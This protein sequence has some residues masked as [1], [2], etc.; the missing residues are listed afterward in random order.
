MN[1]PAVDTPATEEARPVETWL[2]AQVELHRCG[3]SCGAIDGVCGAQTVGALRAFQR[4]HGI[5]ANGDL[6]QPTRDCLRLTAP[7]FTTHTFTD[8]ELAQLHPVPETWLGKSTAPAL[9]YATALEMVAEHYRASQNFVRQH[10]PEVDWADVQ[11]G[12][13]VKV[14][15]VERATIKGRV[16]Q[17]TINLTGHELEG[18]DEVGRV[19]VHCPVSI[20]RMVE[21]RPV[22]EL[23]VKV[24]IPDPNY[25]FD[26]DVF[27]ES[28]EGKE[29]GHKLV[30]PPGP[31]DPVGLAWIGLDVS[32]YGIHGTPDPEKVGRT[33]SHGCFR[34][35]NWDAVMLLGV[36]KVGMTVLVT[37]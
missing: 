1:T 28:A 14:P 19:I 33:E 35:A 10:N 20:A 36:A 16:A 21:K 3:F 17:L 32:G 9:A 18:V 30:I 8:E 7:V 12:T 23:H 24:V 29:L 27:P 13:T 11:A 6:D 22:G 5:A 34:V 4:S 31:N 15:G 2:E 26:P 37:P 25:T